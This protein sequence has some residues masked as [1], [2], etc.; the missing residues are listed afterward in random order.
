M[1][2][3]KISG[4]V[5]ILLMMGGIYGC[6]EEEVIPCECAQIHIRSVSWS[7]WNIGDNEESENSYSVCTEDEFGTS[8]NL[9]RVINVVSDSRIMIAFDE[10]L[11]LC[12][13]SNAKSPLLSWVDVTPDTICFR[14]TTFDAGAYYYLWTEGD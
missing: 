5:L 6:E 8:R 3:L 2:Y 13:E 4:Y 14:T 10:S 1:G 9:F 11:V 7:F 12:E